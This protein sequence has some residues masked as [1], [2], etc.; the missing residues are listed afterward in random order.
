MKLI[1]EVK[2]LTNAYVRKGGKDNRRQQRARMIAFAGFCATQGVNSIGQVGKNHVIQY[3]KSNRNLAES[4]AYS[5]WLAI[6][7][8]WELAGKAGEPPKPLKSDEVHSC[9]EKKVE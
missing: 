2:K 4:T 8:L 6:R 1:N 5:H 9:R 7:T 3:W